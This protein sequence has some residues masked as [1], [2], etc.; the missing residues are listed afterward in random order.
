MPNSV[1]LVMLFM[2]DQGM[3]QLLSSNWKI[4]GEG[5]SAA[6][7]VGRDASASTIGSCVRRFLPTPARAACSPDS[8]LNGANVR[9][10][11]DSTRAFYGKDYD[12]RTILTGKVVS[13][14]QAREFLASVRQNFREANA[15]Q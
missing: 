4:G 6:G 15:A 13:P 11:D 14:P 7:P 3:N 8:P 2:N 12:F 5:W 9:Q 1:D 10:D